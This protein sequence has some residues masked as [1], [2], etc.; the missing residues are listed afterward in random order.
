MKQITK[1]VSEWTKEHFDNTDIE[2][3]EDGNRATY[4]FTSSDKGDFEYRCFVEVYENRPGLMVF[5]YAPFK[6]PQQYRKAVAEVL[7]LSNYSLANGAIGMDMQDGEIRYKA[8]VDV[9]DGAISVAMINQM[10]ECG[11]TI[12]DQYLPAVAAVVYAGQSPEEAFAKADSQDE[13]SEK[14]KSSVEATQDELKHWESFPGNEPIRAWA[15]DLQNVMSSKGNKQ[16]W[17]LAGRAAVI[18]NEDKSYCR[19]VLKRIAADNN[20]QLTVIAADDVM[21]MSP[22]TGMKAMAP[23]LVYLEPGRW[24]RSKADNDENEGTTDSVREFQSRLI[25]YLHSFDPKLPIV[26]VTSASK[27]ES[28]ASRLIKVGL[29][30]RF[31]SIPNEGLEKIGENFLSQIGRDACSDEL[32]N[33]LQK[34]GKL[35]KSEIGDAEKRKLAALCLRRLYQQENRPLAFLDLVHAISHGLLEEGHLKNEDEKRRQYTAIHEAG[36][37][38]VAVLDSD[39]MN[40][41]EYASIIPSVSFKGIV[42]ESYSFHCAHDDIHTYRDFR[43]NIRICLAGRAVEEIA[44]GIENITSGSSSDL[45]NASRSSSSAFAYWGFMP[46]MEIT[47][48]SGANLAAVFDKASNSEM[49]HVETLAREFLEKEYEV[50]KAMLI[51]N[52]SLIDAVAD[53]LLKEPILDQCELSAICTDYRVSSTQPQEF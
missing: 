19:E 6:V 46:Q 27:I 45:E 36:H 30:E 2:V 16:A 32:I 48:R 39:G 10:V 13:I 38:V 41:P 23:A 17:E 50:V 5:H 15:M 42:V 37:V 35:L 21:N 9:E 33:S 12:L 44:F 7:V 20:M 49:L 14:S 3:S 1:V 18:V 40:V 11:N 25:G 31:I 26:Y 34:V 51:Q 47:G 43:H 22:P 8:G 28:V 29:F 24:M 52:R 4:R 53:R